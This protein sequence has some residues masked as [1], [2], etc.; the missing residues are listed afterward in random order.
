M[1]SQS[2]TTPVVGI[3]KV[4]ILP[5]SPV[6]TGYYFP[7]SLSFVE[8]PRLIPERASRGIRGSG[9]AT[10]TYLRAYRDDGQG[11]INLPGN[12]IAG[13]YVCITLGT[14]SFS[15]AS[16]VWWGYITNIDK[17]AFA[18]AIDV[19]GT[20]TAVG[21]GRLLEGNTLTG[22]RQDGH[23]SA[24][25]PLLSVP[26]ANM[27][28][29]EGE[30]IGNMVSGQD[31]FGHAVPVFAD[32]PA[33]C[34]GIWSRYD[35]LNHCLRFCSP[36]GIPLVNIFGSAGVLTYFQ[37]TTSKEVMEL[38]PLAMSGLLDLI[39]SRARGFCWDLFPATDGTWTVYVYAMGDSP[40]AYGAGY[41]AQTPINIDV[42]GTQIAEVEY[43]ED[44]SDLIDA[45]TVEGDNILIGS[46]VA[47]SDGNLFSG[48]SNAQLTAFR[49]GAVGGTINGTPYASL[50]PAQK[51]EANT[52]VRSG[53]PLRDVFELFG[54]Y[55]ASATLTRSATP[56]LGAGSLPLVPNVLWD[57]TTATVDDTTSRLPYLPSL[58]LSRMIPWL[59]GVKGDGTDTRSATQQAY[60]AYLEPR[61]FRYLGSPATG[62]GVLQDLLVDYKN[63]SGPSV[64]PDDRG[65]GL[66][67]AFTPREM[68]AKNNWTDGTDGISKLSPI[69]ANPYGVT[70]DIASLVCTIGI[71]SDQKVSVTKYRTGLTAATAR[72]T[73]KLSY[74]HLQC[75]VMTGGAIV[76][77]NANGSADSVTATKITR[78]DWPTAERLA[79]QYASFFFRQRNSA[80]I[81]L[82]VPSSP[83]GSWGAIGQLIGTVTERAAYGTYPALVT[84]AFTIIEAIDYDFG[85]SPSLTFTTTLPESPALQAQVS[86]PA[87]GG[88]VSASLGATVPQAIKQT[89]NAVA[90]LKQQATRSPAVAARPAYTVPTSGD[91]VTD[92]GI[93]QT[94]HGFT[95][96]NAIYRT[97]GSWAKAKSDQVS[98]AGYEG[99]V[100][101][102]TDANTFDVVYAGAISGLSISGA[103]DGVVYYLSDTTA[104][105]LVPKSS[106][107][108]TALIVPVLVATGTTTGLVIPG[109]QQ[110]VDLNSLRLGDATNG[111][112]LM[113]AYFA[114][115]KYLDLAANGTLTIFQSASVKV[116]IDQNCVVTITQA[117]S[118]VSIDANSTVTITYPNSNTVTIA[119]ADFV[120]TGKAVKLR[121]LDICDATGLAKKILALCS[122]AY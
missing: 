57:G 119:S 79:S 66:R 8:E 77:V 70:I 18:G 20:V 72:R 69:N 32:V 36:A 48:F 43:T 31:D 76:G 24:A 115:A 4:W 74:P 9:S 111:G 80:K 110:G 120:G 109:Q 84:N 47:T 44:A 58:R 26:S 75:W 50:T 25:K 94:S 60:P 104:G 100:S 51:Q 114:A 95:V 22:F 81:K 42:S 2:A 88:S 102:V 78:N 13:A 90:Q 93:S 15:Y 1:S 65:P 85:S 96:G 62:D 106:L 33:S 46:T 116:T 103:T 19:L 53:A 10:F 49:T 108:A 71:P 61:V 17:T 14:N 86:S 52:Q 97:A 34:G 82:A 89:Q 83:P 35:V 38:Y 118:S 56:G 68:L 41:P 98:T 28:T 16:V 67:I 6:G 107:G 27:A 99:V 45:V 101:N 23:G 11:F 91:S 55:P 12:V 37:D 54:L 73:A 21:L 39:A 117:S 63:R 112:A 105:A 64:S 121:E 5:A 92:T 122:A 30:I 40:T 3:A 7:W 29:A 113:R 87:M 59:Q